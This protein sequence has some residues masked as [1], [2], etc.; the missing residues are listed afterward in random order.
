MQLVEKNEELDR[1]SFVELHKLRKYVKRYRYFIRFFASLIKPA[2][3][4][5]ASDIITPMQDCLGDIN[6]AHVGSKILQ[7]T[8]DGISDE[9]R[10]GYL[11]TN[12]KLLAHFSNQANEKRESYD[13]HWQRF[14]TL[15]ISQNDFI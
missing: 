4:A 7:Q 9:K 14:Q 12:A 2:V 5:R 13:A 10:Q 11:Q 1:H 15:K 6:D 8:M 3:V